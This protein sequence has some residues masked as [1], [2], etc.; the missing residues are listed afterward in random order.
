M[1]RFVAV[2]AA[3]VGLAPGA[4]HAA[5]LYGVGPFQAFQAQDLFEIDTTT[6]EA[7]LIGSTGLEQVVGMAWDEA[8]STMYAYTA[9]ADLYSVDLSSGATTLVAAWAATV[10]EGGLAIDAAGIAYTANGTLLATVDLDTADLITVGPFGLAGDD[11]S[12]LAFACDGTLFGYAKNGTL[13][14]ALVTID[15]TTGEATL[16]DTLTGIL[17]DASMGGLDVDPDSDLLYLSDSTNLYTVDPLTASAT[18][19]GGHGVT[20]LGAI[21]F[22]PEPSVICLLCL[23]AVLPRPRRRR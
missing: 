5:T 2:M 15:A 23:G 3:V 14:D 22:V 13:D 20:G 17:G 9:Q 16:V 7:T 6:G 11:V 18:W 10:P 8:D 12:G 4:V 1:R 19:I 21:A